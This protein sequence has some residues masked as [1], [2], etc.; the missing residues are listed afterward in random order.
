MLVLEELLDVH[1]RLLGSQNNS[2]GCPSQWQCHHVPRSPSVAGVILVRCLRTDTVLLHFL[3]K[4]VELLNLKP[5]ERQDQ[6][7]VFDSQDLAN[8]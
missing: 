6:V 5:E 1:H 3:V 7:M 2:R 8:T 4:F